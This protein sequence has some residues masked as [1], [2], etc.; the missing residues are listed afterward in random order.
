MDYNYGY[1]CH[2]TCGYWSSPFF[3][4]RRVSAFYLCQMKLA[5]L[6]NFDKIHEEVAKVMEQVITD[7]F[8]ISG[9]SM[10]REGVVEQLFSLYRNIHHNDLQKQ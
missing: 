9:K 1:N 7:V 8:S 10:L 2:K 5:T 6:E 3:S 4:Q